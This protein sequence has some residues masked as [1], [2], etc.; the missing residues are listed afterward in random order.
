MCVF[1]VKRIKPLIW[2]RQLIVYR[3]EVRH[4][5]H[6]S[7]LFQS[8]L[9]TH[10]R[11]SKT[12]INQ[13][14][15]SLMCWVLHPSSTRSFPNPPSNP[16]LSHNPSLP[17]LLYQIPSAFTLS[18]F[19]CSLLHLSN[20]ACRCWDISLCPTFNMMPSL[21]VCCV[22]LPHVLSL[23]P[24]LNDKQNTWLNTS[25]SIASYSSTTPTAHYPI[26]QNQTLRKLIKQHLLWG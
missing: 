4:A 11:R 3:L 13:I 20:T 12:G 22:K 19:F 10:S 26:L 25:Q 7:H 17:L 14:S 24:K 5:I 21:D 8:K 6:S 18:L 2:S 1:S 15:C 16:L 23:V 9:N